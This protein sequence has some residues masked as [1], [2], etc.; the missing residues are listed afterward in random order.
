LAVWIF[1]IE[2]CPDRDASGSQPA[3]KQ[4]DR[5]AGRQASRSGTQRQRQ[6]T[7]GYTHAPQSQWAGKTEEIDGGFR[8][9]GGNG[10][11]DG[12]PTGW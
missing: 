6:G 1:V 5:Q 4:A 2:R 9:A 8:P 3:K 12:I 7:G 10:G 11:V